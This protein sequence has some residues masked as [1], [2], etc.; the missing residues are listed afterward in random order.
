MAGVA[1][2]IHTDHLN[3]TV[4]NQALK[5]P[6]KILRMLSKIEA[7][8]VPQGQL[9]PGRGQTGDGISRNPVDRGDARFNAEEK[10]HMPKTLREAFEVVSK[11]GLD[12]PNLVDDA[13][14]YTQLKTFMRESVVN[15]DDGESRCVC[16]SCQFVGKPDVVNTLCKH[17]GTGTIRTTPNISSKHTLF[18][19]GF[20]K[21]GEYLDQVR[22]YVMKGH[23][24]Q[25]ETIAVLTPHLA[26][27]LGS[28]R[29]LEEFAAQR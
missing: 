17:A 10:P 28:H 13:E 19:P 1:V 23:H 9:P 15:K 25:F 21:K 8:L 11:I 18:A 14:A 22:G 4:L 27:P 3:S 6:D 26:I 20:E 7:L 2:A 5:Q 16:A 29:W 24:V 12:G